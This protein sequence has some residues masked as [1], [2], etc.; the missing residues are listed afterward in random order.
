[1]MRYNHYLIHQLNEQS[2]IQMMNDKNISISMS[3]MPLLVISSCFTAS[4][5]ERV[6]PDRLTKTNATTAGTKKSQRKVK[7]R[8]T[9]RCIGYIFLIIFDAQCARPLR[10]HLCCPPSS[11]YV[12]FFIPFFFDHFFFLTQKQKTHR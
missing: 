8:R 4:T 3:A 6:K 12:I 1:M 9:A 2:I 11:T 5:D 7:N 10:L